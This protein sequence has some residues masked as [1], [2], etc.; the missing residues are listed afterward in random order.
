MPDSERSR[1]WG[2]V[3]LGTEAPLILAGITLA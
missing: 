3:G 1:D 2:R